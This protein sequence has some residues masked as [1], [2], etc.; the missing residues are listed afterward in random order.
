MWDICFQVVWKWVQRWLSLYK[1]KHFRK[2]SVLRPEYQ[3]WLVE[4]LDEWGGRITSTVL[5]FSFGIWQAF[6]RWGWLEDLR[7]ETR[8]WTPS[9]QRIS[10]CGMVMNWKSMQR[11]F[12]S[13][14]VVAMISRCNVVQVHYDCKFRGLDVVSSRSAR[15]LGGNRT[16]A[17]V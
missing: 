8:Q 14:S 5:W 1:S 13:L 11:L 15:L 2:S 12:S 17:E 9:L 4:W 10:S 7:S 3:R 16:L 6:L